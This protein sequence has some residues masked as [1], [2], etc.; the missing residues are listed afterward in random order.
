MI[1]LLAGL[2]A[3]LRHWKSAAFAVAILFAA[4]SH[5]TRLSTE[6][7]LERCRGEVAIAQLK[8]ERSQAAIAALRRDSLRRSAEQARLV[9]EA[10]RRNKSEQY[11]IEALQRSARLPA[12]GDRCPLSD[13]LRQAEDGL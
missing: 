11:R 1:H 7:R 4:G 2:P 6:R 12:E 3:V 8:L 10:E 9:G 5:L 13:A